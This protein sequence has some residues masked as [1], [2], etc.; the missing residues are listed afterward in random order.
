MKAAIYCRVST[1]MQEDNYSLP[2]QEEACRKH[3]AALGYEVAA[4]YQDVHSG[5]ELWERKGLTAL[6][7]AARTGAY[8]A[9]IAYEPDRLSRRQVHS[10]VLIDECERHGVE[11]LFV[12][13]QHD[14]TALGEF[15]AN[16]RT[17][18]AEMEREKF[19]ERSM[20][21]IQ[22]RMQSGKLRPSNRPLYGYQ[23]ADEDKS[24]YAIDEEKAAN[25]R[26]LFNGIAGGMTLR[27]MADV[28][29]A[30][31]VPTANGGAKWNHVVIRA[32]LYHPGYMGVAV[33]NQTAR[34]KA[35]GK[36]IRT[37]RPE[38]EHIIL[39]EGTIPPIVTPE[40]FAAVQ[41]RLTRN[42]AEATRN[43]QN[44]EAFLLRSGF[45]VCGYCGR[46]IRSIWTK[47]CPNQPARAYYANHA[48]QHP[49]EDCPSFAMSA[50]KLDAAVWARVEATLTHP[51][52]IAA[53]VE[54][55]RR[56]DPTHADLAT[57]ARVLNEVARKQANLSRSLAL[58][59]DADAAAPIIAE[60]RALGERKRELDTE[61][62]ALRARQASWQASQDQITSLQAWVTTVATNLHTERYSDR[63][64]WLAALG[65]QVKL[66]RKDHA[67]RYEI[68][69]SLPLDTAPPT[70]IVV[71]RG[72]VLSPS[73]SGHR[74]SAR[75]APSF[76]PAASRRSDRLPVTEHAARSPR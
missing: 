58:L 2:T 6:R 47:D 54:A 31:S 9:I 56:D 65:V 37:P 68:I 5:Y 76:L 44:A 1:T 16:V 30:E 71:Q 74:A 66:Y 22:A 72:A 33:C 7:E 43:N 45:I 40:V 20:R 48:P 25:V 55:L 26:R 23:W 69:A 3:A 49:H 12:I 35:R 32:M 19:K 62:D 70:S 4:L 57:V 28:L 8:D 11:L 61:Q 41:A 27:G 67:P 15:L 17:F 24:R 59:D 50:R 52:T 42:K 46:P 10:A 36:Q 51:E 38:E 13:G 73:H 18:A 14:K 21:G 63:R 29:N 53:E 64:D 34:T 60:L 39:P 75:R